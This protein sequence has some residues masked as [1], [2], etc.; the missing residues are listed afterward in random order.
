VKQLLSSLLDVRR[1]GPALVYAIKGLQATYRHESAFR[2]ELIASVLIIPLG[3]WLGQ[4][5]YER[6][7]LVGSWLLV[8]LVEVLNSAIESVIDLASPDRHELA[9]RGKDQ[10]AAAVLLC[11]VLTATVWALVLWPRWF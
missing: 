4:S 6:A 10:A 8:P 11:L 2:Q 3:I 9:G 7:L 5:G 1:V